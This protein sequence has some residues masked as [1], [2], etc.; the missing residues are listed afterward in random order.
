MCLWSIPP[1]PYMS[2]V[3]SWSNLLWMEDF[4]FLCNNVIEYICSGIHG[5]NA[6]LVISL[7]HV[8]FTGSDLHR[9]WRT[10]STHGLFPIFRLP[11]FFYT[12]PFLSHFCL[13]N[14]SFY[15]VCLDMCGFIPMLLLYVHAVFSCTS[16]DYPYLHIRT[17][18][19]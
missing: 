19:L 2:S 13:G 7:L 10:G 8:F 18:C 3:Y 17:L 11:F 5:G 12:P 4:F 9:R 14:I 6:M 15:F 16:R 1:L